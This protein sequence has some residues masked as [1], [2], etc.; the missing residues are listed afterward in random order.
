ALVHTGLLAAGAKEGE[1]AQF[2]PTYRPATGSV[3]EVTLHWTDETG[4]PQQGRGQ[5][6]VRNTKTG[7]A[8][9]E[10][11]VFAGSG[12]WVDEATQRREYMAE[13]G[14]LVCVSNFPD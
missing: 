6:W 5:N 8:M 2:H 12:F 13:N 14:N 9:A 11:W 10:P 3:I 1:P 7:E 4:Q